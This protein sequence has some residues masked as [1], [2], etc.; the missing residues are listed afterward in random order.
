MCGI[1]GIYS[2]EGI[3][4]W[5][6]EKATKVLEH[7][8]PDNCGFFF[9]SLI[10]LGHKRLS[11]IDL[12]E[13]GKQPMTNEK[14]DMWIVYNGEIYNFQELRKELEM[15]GHKFKSDTDSEVVLHAYEQWQ[16]KCLEKFNGMFVFAI[17]DD[18]NKM[19]FLARDRAG[20]KPLYYYFDKNKFIFASEIKAIL[21]FN[22]K[23]QTAQYLPGITVVLFPGIIS[24]YIR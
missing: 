20:I 13:R 17:W 23:K 12:S 9:D 21:E 24:D 7:R 11:I 8:G 6:V 5:Q 2:K 15:K 18:K 22:M 10:A 14:E 16:E 19:F 3:D 4:K 1:V